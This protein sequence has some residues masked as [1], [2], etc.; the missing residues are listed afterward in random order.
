M[1][2]VKDLY[3]RHSKHLSLD[4]VAGKSG[5]SKRIKLAEAQ[6]PGLA[7]SG[8]LKNHSNR[9]FLVF[10]KTEMEYVKELAL[11]VRHERLEALI[12]PM[13]PSIIISRRYKPLKEMIELCDK[14][15]VPLFRTTLS[16][17]L[18]LN[19]LSYILNEEIAPKT[20]CHGTL[21][22]IFGVGIL[23][24]GES[25]IGKSE[26]ALDL[27]ERGHRLIADDSVQVKR[28]RGPYL[29]GSCN[30]V[31]GHHMEVRGVGIIN[32]AHLYG[33]IS[34]SNCKTIDMAVKLVIWKDKP[35]EDRAG[36]E[37]KYISILNT[38]VPYFE[39]S[40]KP[41][42]NVAL[43]LEA[44]ALNYHTKKMGYHSAHVFNRKQLALTMP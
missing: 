18:L 15:C 28:K 25:G 36:L 20:Y 31:A 8:Y 13:T 16:T 30:N 44:L 2:L 35:L 21:M 24:Q 23:I 6:R 38:E 9:R 39:L 29:E 4:L 43:L 19:E 12:H 22:E 26:T 32:I 14:K 7:L 5:L 3:E 37:D 10:G 17:H 40:V 34:V 33:S 1:Y 11:E 42:R 41:G 27:I